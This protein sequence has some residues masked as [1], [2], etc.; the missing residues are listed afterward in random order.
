LE[1]TEK[2]K[3]TPLETEDATLETQITELLARVSSLETTT[4]GS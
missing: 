1:T 3:T 4:D 2:E